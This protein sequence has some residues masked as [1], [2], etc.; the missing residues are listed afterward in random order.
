MQ[1]PKVLLCRAH[2]W[3]I[4]YDVPIDHEVADAIFKRSIFDWAICIWSLL[5]VY[6]RPCMHACKSQL[7]G[8]YDFKLNQCGETY[9]ARSFDSFDDTLVIHW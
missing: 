5:V 4:E 3:I 1:M 6:N 2:N 7:L 9:Y 8:W